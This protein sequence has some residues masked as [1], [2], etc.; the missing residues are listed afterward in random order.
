[1]ISRG[2]FLGTALAG[3]GL[4]GASLPGGRHQPLLRPEDPRRTSC[5]S[6][7][8]CVNAHG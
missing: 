3:A 2:R 6:T 8:A 5:S 1:M 7:D 4:P